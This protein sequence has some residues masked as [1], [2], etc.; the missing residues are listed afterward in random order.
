[1]STGT[2]RIAVPPAALVGQRGRSR[3]QWFTRQDRVAY[4]FLLPFMLLF[5]VIT[6][7]PFVTGF[8][9]SFTDKSPLVPDTHWVGLDN[10]TTLLFD[11]SLFR[12]SL[13]NTLFYVLLL[14]PAQAV[15][16]LLLALYV[17]RKLFG[18]QLSRLAFFAPFVLSVSV[19]GIVW[20]WILETRYGLLNLALGDLGLP[21]TTPW[22]TNVH[23]VMVGIVL[24]SLW[25]H[26]GFSMVLFLAGLQD[27]PAELLEVAQID[28]AGAWQRLRYV[29]LPLLRPV[30]LLVVV[31]SVIDAMK[32]FG[33]PWFMTNGGPAGASTT[34]VYDL[35]LNFQSLHMG[36]ASAIGFC[37][38]VII[39]ALA[40]VRQVFVREEVG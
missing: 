21:A 34:V 37:L 27:I 16:G 13:S 23:W 9:F 17:N 36:Y 22:L 32:V 31:L 30:V 38:L 19:V 6:L 29:T 15:L 11:D 18:H 39:L 5:T 10:Y 35:Y 1:V 3:R 20:G 4:S 40:L 12:D 8:I 26:V 2:P 25:W 24:S 33:Q 28:G 14:V 7:Y